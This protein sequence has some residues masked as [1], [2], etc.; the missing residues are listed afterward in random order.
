MLKLEIRITSSL[1][2]HGNELAWAILRLVDALQKG[3]TKDVA[4]NSR[5]FE[6]THIMLAI[7]GSAAPYRTLSNCNTPSK[8]T[9]APR[10]ALAGRKSTCRM[11]TSLVR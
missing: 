1:H 3:Q 4:L 5:N 6:P 10:F 8:I 11:M 7:E 9:Q 2:T